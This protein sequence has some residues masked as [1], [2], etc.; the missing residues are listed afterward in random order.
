MKYLITALLLLATLSVGNAQDLTVTTVDFA[1][2]ISERSP[3]G[4]DTTFSATVGTVYCFSRVQGATDTTNIDHVWY[5]KDQE[6]ARIN[7]A[8]NTDDWR[9]W[10][11]KKILEQW[12]GRWRVLIED[13]NG[14]VLDSKS[15]VIRE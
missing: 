6:K 4:V 11:S 12:T 15:F 5:Y 1:T 8:V 9:T 7:L 10:S 13:A 2:S 3:V 14:R